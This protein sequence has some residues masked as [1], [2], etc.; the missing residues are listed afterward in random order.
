M[1]PTPELKVALFAANTKCHLAA[2]VQVGFSLPGNNSLCENRFAQLSA[3]NFPFFSR[4]RKGTTAKTWPSLQAV[5]F[6][7][8]VAAFTLTVNIEETLVSYV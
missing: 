1:N 4:S 8:N 6:V 2:F 7:S 3:S 5:T